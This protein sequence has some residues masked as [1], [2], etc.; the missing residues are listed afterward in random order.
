MSMNLTPGSLVQVKVTKNPTSD[1][2]AKTLSRIFGHDLAVKRQA[3]RR[4]RI[5]RQETDPRRRG[6]RLWNVKDRAPRIAQPGKGDS[7]KVHATLDLIN[8]LGSVERFVEV[9]ATT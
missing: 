1:R 8:D 6:G 5:L 9:A 3:R 2:A 4:Q 7:C